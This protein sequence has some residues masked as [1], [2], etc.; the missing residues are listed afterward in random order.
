MA[1]LAA[2]RVKPQGNGSADVATPWEQ[3]SAAPAG[4]KLMLNTIGREQR[5]TDAALTS[6]GVI[7]W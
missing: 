6:A 5:P 7:A 1:S 3:A 2:G 4:G